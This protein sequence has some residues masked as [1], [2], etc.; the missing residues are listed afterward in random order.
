[1]PCIRLTRAMYLEFDIIPCTT[2]TRAM[3]LEFDMIPC[4][5]LTR[6][7]HSGFV[8]CM[9]VYNMVGMAGMAGYGDIFP[10]K[11][12]KRNLVYPGSA[13]FCLLTAFA[14]EFL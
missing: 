14:Y 12:K 2:L 11:K 8:L 10:K 6:A 4:I 9:A 13:I 5:M 1:M 7:M 3:Y